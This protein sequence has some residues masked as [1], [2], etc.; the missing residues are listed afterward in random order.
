M[1]LKIMPTSPTVDMAKLKEDVRAKTVEI[2]AKIMQDQ[3]KEEPVAFG[4]VAL[5][6]T[7][8]WPED[9]DPDTVEVEMVKVENVNSIQVI[10]VRRA[11]A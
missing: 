7:V 5:V 11:I 8:V 3:I 10:D 2:D 9:R 1:T 6:L 4:L